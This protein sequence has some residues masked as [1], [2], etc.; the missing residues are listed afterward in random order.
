[1]TVV[2]TVTRIVCRDGFTLTVSSDVRLN[3]TPA[4][5]GRPATV[6]V[7]YPSA[8]PEPWEPVDGPLYWSRYAE[9]PDLPT[10]TVYDH[11]PVTLV[12]LL[13]RLHGGAR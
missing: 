12:D 11:V 1:M 7:G 5:P 8:R 2:P 9:D 4:T 3:S 6:E 13:V 10:D